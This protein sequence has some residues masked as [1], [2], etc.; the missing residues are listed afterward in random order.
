MQALIAGSFLHDGPRSGAIL[1]KP[2][3]LDARR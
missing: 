2:G 3:H 1:L